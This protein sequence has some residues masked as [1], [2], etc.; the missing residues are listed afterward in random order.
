MESIQQRDVRFNG[1]HCQLAIQWLS[2][3]VV[4][5]KINGIDAG[6][7]GGA[8][9]LELNRHL[10]SASPIQLFIDARGVRSASIDVSGDW[11]IWLAARREQLREVHMLTGSRFIQI[12]ATFVRRFADLQSIM[13]VY[14]DAAA[15]EETLAEALAP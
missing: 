9:M 15:F 7:F 1:V 13:R 10:D 2:R 4:M 14:T 11:A 8:P 6:E 5:L 3:R 12:T